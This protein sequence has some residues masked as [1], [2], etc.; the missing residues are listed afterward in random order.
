MWH[1]ESGEAGIG[2]TPKGIL[3]YAEDQV[4]FC[5][6]NSDTPSSTFDVSAGNDGF[7]CYDN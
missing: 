1:Q 2:G 7:S 3:G 4:V 6:F 5:D